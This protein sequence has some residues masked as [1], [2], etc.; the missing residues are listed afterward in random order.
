MSHDQYVCL[1]KIYRK[2]SFQFQR[3][4]NVRQSDA[5]N[6]DLSFGFNYSFYSNRTLRLLAIIAEDISEEYVVK[7]PSAIMSLCGFV[8][9]L[10]P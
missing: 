2:F 4:K 1:P 8:V 10:E 5:L 6:K 9:E 7:T 3:C